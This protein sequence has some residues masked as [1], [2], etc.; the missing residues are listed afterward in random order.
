MW[1]ELYLEYYFAS[2]NPKTPK[3]NKNTSEKSIRNQTLAAS[4]HSSSLAPSLLLSISSIFG[5]K[6]VR[7]SKGKNVVGKNT[8]FHALE[9]L[10]ICNQW[11]CYW[12]PANLFSQRKA[13]TE[14]IY[15]KADIKVCS[16][17]WSC[18]RKHSE[19]TFRI[20]A[21]NQFPK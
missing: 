5:N 21:R 16:F 14:K 10:C 11:F 8:N 9:P 18:N 13:T 4:T 17:C 12:S 15:Q 1:V 19:I 3:H 2:T 20:M 6:K 7:G